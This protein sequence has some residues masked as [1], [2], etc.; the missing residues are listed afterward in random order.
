MIY[1]PLLVRKAQHIDCFVHFFLF[2]E[3]EAKALVHSSGVLKSLQTTCDA[4]HVIALQPERLKLDEAT[5]A[6]PGPE[7]TRLIR[8]LS[9]EAKNA[10]RLDVVKHLRQ[11]TP[12]GTTG[13]V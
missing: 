12:A 9:I 5:L 13:V 8:C 3:S 1:I 2:V 11:I 7:K 10:K 6:D 4:E